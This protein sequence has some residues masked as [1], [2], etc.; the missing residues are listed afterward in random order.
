VWSPK[1]ITDILGEDAAVEFSGYY[2]INE[3]GNFEEKSIPNLLHNEEAFGRIPENPMEEYRQKVYLEREKRVHPYKDDKILV[4]WNGLMIAALAMG[5]RVLG[6]KR[7]AEAAEKAAAFI[8]LKLIRDDG[9][10]LARYR[11]GEAAYLGYLDDYAFLIWGL[12]ELYETTFRAEHL[13]LAL[14]LNKDMLKYFQD[15][16]NGG[17]YL[18]GSDSEQLIVRPKDVYDGATP[19][20]NSVAAVNFLR[21]GRITGDADLEEM[22]Y[23]QLNAFGSM[24]EEH[25]MGY[26]HMLITLLFANS[27][28]SEIV[29]VGN[30]EDKNARRMLEIVDRHFL[31]FNVVLFKDAEGLEAGI[32]EIVTFTEGQIMIE[33]KATA[34]VCENFACH[35]PV[36]NI[37][38]LENYIKS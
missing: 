34:Y 11:D 38:E 17:L 26:T 31:P 21:L 35:A 4:S 27:K 10:L 9:R 20:G 2:G 6:I 37:D 18:Y 13:K 22:A 28:A 36:T 1:E 15:E 33:D 32:T 30:R 14:D 23:E 8:K 16:N 5:A 25:P 29:I 7:Y 24:I 12:I 3:K 19:S